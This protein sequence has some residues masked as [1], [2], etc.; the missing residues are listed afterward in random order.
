MG[1]SGRNT[2]TSNCY[3]AKD[4]RELWSWAHRPLPH[5]DVSCVLLL[6]LFKLLVQGHGETG[7]G[8]PVPPSMSDKDAVP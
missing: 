5:P 6:A 3:K 1:E 7:F 8:S 2:L 4:D